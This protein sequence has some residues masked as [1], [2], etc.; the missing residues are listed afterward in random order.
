MVVMVAVC[1]GGEDARE[2]RLWLA[3]CRLVSTVKFVFLV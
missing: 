1:K 3:I 2:R